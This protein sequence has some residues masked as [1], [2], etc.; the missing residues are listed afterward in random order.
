MGD[1]LTAQEAANE[2]GYHVNHVYRLLRLGAMHGELVHGRVWLID[3]AEVEHIKAQ[4][5]EHGRYHH[6]KTS[7]EEVIED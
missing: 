7:R 2:L 6:G 3:R 5:N 4:Q 1:K